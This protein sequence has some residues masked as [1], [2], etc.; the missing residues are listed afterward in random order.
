MYKYLECKFK[1]N[2]FRVNINFLFYYNI[3]VVSR[4]LNGFT[5][6]TVTIKFSCLKILD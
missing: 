6:D 5:K 2:K 1:F 3:I 4:H